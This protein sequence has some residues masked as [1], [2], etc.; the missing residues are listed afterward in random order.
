[1]QLAAISCRIYWAFGSSHGSKSLS[2]GTVL[3]TT[4]VLIIFI[5]K[6]SEKILLISSKC[7]NKTYEFNY[8]QWT[9][10]LTNLLDT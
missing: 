2:I 8:E 7:R 5:N 10:W 4:T 6:M 1:M 3:K 9:D